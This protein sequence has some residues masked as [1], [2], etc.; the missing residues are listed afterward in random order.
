MPIYAQFKARHCLNA[1]IHNTTQSDILRKTLSYI[2]DE[3]I[4]VTLLDVKNRMNYY[5]NK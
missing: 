5:V 4:Q 1:M 2:N 3:Y